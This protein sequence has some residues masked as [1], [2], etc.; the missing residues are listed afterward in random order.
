MKTF[1]SASHRMAIDQ[2]SPFS[3]GQ[4]HL[5]V[6]FT[7]GEPN[8]GDT[9]NV[10]CRITSTADLVSIGLLVNVLRSKKLGLSLQ[11]YYLL[12]ARMDRRLSP[13]EPHTLRVMCDI[14]NS[15][16]LASVSVFVPH[17]SI[18]AELL[19]RYED[20]PDLVEDC[21]YDV[22]VRR[23]LQSCLKW[24]GPLD[25]NW[26]MFSKTVESMSLVFPDAG[27]T[28]RFGKMKFVEWYGRSE[29]V[30]LFKD[31]NERTGKILGTKIMSGAVREHCIIVDDLCDGGAT[32]KSAAETLRAAGAKTV[33]L[34]V[35]HGIFA[36]GTRIDGVDFVATSNSYKDHETH[37]ALFVNKIN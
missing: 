17:S 30:T 16:G 35:A 3:D 29:I 15:Y 8:R 7:D 20:F 24:D 25:E 2:G 36:K 10:A 14:L 28:K 4:P 31:R 1:I 11:V 37:E 33:S 21:F 23:C 32:F 5:A 6:A 9:V 19:D 34:V 18:T 13:H 12:G 22:C 26:R 27:A